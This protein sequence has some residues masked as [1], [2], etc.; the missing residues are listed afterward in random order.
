MPKSLLKES[1]PS[2]YCGY[3]QQQHLQQ[4]GS[5]ERERERVNRSTLTFFSPIVVSNFTPV[6]KSKLKKDSNPLQFEPIKLSADLSQCLSPFLKA[7]DL[8][9]RQS[10]GQAMTDR[11]LDQEHGPNEDPEEF[12]KVV[13]TYM[14]VDQSV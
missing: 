12:S 6:I 13:K 4:C 3:A 5:D 2:R 11:L 14:M 8:K 9:L 1:S 7:R 10:D